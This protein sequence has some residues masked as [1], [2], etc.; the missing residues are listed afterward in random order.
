MVAAAP[1]KGALKPKVALALLAALF[2][3]FI[4]MTVLHQKFKTYNFAPLEKSPEVLA[5]KA[6]TILEK[7]GYADA[8]ADSVYRFEPDNSFLNRADESIDDSSQVKKML[9][10]GQPFEIYFLYRQ[11][12]NYLEPQESGNVTEFEPPLTVQN[13]ANVKLDTRGRLI[14]LVAVPPQI[15][16]QTEKRE[17]DWNTL[18]TE[19]GLDIL[20]FKETESNRTPPVFA[21]ERRAW[22]GSLA[23]LPEIPVRIEAASFNGKAVYFS[24]VA[25]WNNPAEN[26][27]NKRKCFSQNG[28]D[29]DYFDLLSGHC[30]LDFAR[31]S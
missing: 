21:D 18:F 24:V 20:K 14:E 12:P 1:K 25:P 7:A 4:L 22:E 31:P 19:A 8:A 3:A 27:R 16:G 2:A 11:S 23:D 26:I 28:R 5:E 10:F 6:E 9:G 30:R 15:A 29:L 17:T 13:M